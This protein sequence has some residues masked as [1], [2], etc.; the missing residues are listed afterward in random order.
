MFLLNMVAYGQMKNTFEMKNSFLF[1]EFWSWSKGPLFKNFYFADDGSFVYNNGYSGAIWSVN[2]SEGTYTYDPYIK[3]IRLRVNKKYSS[4]LTVSKEETPSKLTLKDFNDTR[5]AVLFGNDRLNVIEMGRTVGLTTDQYWFKGP[6][7]SHDLIQFTTFGQATIIQ[8][9][10]V[11]RTYFCHYHI[12]DH[13]L[14]LE[15]NSMTTE[16]D[17]KEKK[18]KTFAPASKTFLKIDIHKELVRV[19]KMDLTKVID[20]T[21]NWQFRNQKFHIENMVLTENEILLEEFN[22][23]VKQ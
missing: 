7:S 14:L 11:K 22:R 3:E 23:V 18:I 12:Y 9:T 13:L 20:G 15:I 10:D 21:R 5:V 16:E 4:G 19:E 2:T 17:G 6:N 1:N 8:E